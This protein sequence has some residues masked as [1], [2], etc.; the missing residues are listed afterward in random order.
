MAI[1]RFWPFVILL[2]LLNFQ[3]RAEDADAPEAQ[4]LDAPSK[5]IYATPTL[6]F[7]P[8]PGE[9][10]AE[11]SLRGIQLLQKTEDLSSTVADLKRNQ[12][13][14]ATRFATSLGGVMYGG[15]NLVY[16]TSNSTTTSTT[17]DDVVTDTHSESSSVSDPAFNLG[18]RF[19]DPGV[20]STM[21]L[22]VAVPGIQTNTFAPSATTY[23]TN[24][25][26]T[27][28]PSFAVFTND[29]ESSLWSLSMSYEFVSGSHSEKLTKAGVQTVT[30]T[31]GGNR[32]TLSGTW[33]QSGQDRALG[34][35]LVYT[36]VEPTRLLSGDTETDNDE[37]TFLTGQVY[38]RIR[39]D[40]NFQIFPSFSLERMQTT[41]K[42]GTQI[43]RDD[44]YQLALTGRCTF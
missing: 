19:N 34:L 23:S 2:I 16:T 41:S 3:A 21:N 12:T 42:N 31:Q 24:T 15:I 44:T 27:W 37:T 25:N 4:E 1:M 39:L 30:D 43:F 40:P 26:V 13:Q 14:F 7:A 28:T 5:T 9:F 38:Y 36:L 29:P 10:W 11:M 33:E 20:S 18:A 35:Q 8:N 17:I 32:T 6:V 22:S